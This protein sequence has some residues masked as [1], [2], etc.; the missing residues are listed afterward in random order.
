MN[1]TEVKVKNIINIVDSYKYSGEDGKSVK[2]ILNYNNVVAPVISKLIN[3]AIYE[4]KYLICL[5]LAKSYQYSIQDQ[6]HYRKL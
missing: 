3:Q 4:G 6:K 2:I 5:K 1:V